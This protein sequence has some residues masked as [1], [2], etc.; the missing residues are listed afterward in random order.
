MCVA[1]YGATMWHVYSRLLTLDEQI[2][3]QAV[4]S[5]AGLMMV[6]ILTFLGVRRVTWGGDLSHLRDISYK[7]CNNA[8]G[9]NAH[10]V[11]LL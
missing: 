1:E 8:N 7:D 6:S 4:R 9:R 3:I 11:G 5:F 10:L 2:G